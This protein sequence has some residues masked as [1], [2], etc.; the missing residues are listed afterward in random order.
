MPKGL[1]EDWYIRNALLTQLGWSCSPL[2]WG[3]R[4]GSR[5]STPGGGGIPG[6]C[7]W[8]AAVGSGRWRLMSTMM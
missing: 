5:E 3:S 4:R 6:G 2:G 8:A 7:C 1:G